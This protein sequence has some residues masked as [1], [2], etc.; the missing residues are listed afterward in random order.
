M[1]QKTEIDHD[2]ELEISTVVPLRSHLLGV[3]GPGLITGA[4]DDDPSGIATYSQ[5]GAQFGYGFGWTMIYSLPLMVAVQMIS[6]RIGR[7][8]GRGLAGV[9]RL[10]YPNWLLQ[11]SVGLLLIAN[12]INLGADLGAMGDALNLLLPGATWLYVIFFGSLCIAMQ[13][14]FTYARY[15]SI[16]KWLTLSLFA[17]LAT[18]AVVHVDWSTM[19]FHAFIPQ[20]SSD[21][22]FL[23]TIVAVFGTTISPYLFFWQSSEE[24]EDVLHY[25]ERTELAKAPEQ[26]PR[27]LERIEVDTIVGMSFSN[28][29][30][31]SIL[32]TAAATFHV[33]GVTDIQTSAQA[34]D[35]LRPLAGHFA[36]LIFTLGI[37]GT[38]FLA[39]PVLA[40]SA[41]YAVGEAMRW[42]VGFGRQMQEAKAFYATVILA[43]IVG[44]ILNFSSINP[45]KALF[46]SAVINGVVAVPIMIIMML[47]A[48]RRD[49]LGRFAIHGWLKVLGWTATALMVVCVVAMFSNLAL[50][51]KS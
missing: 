40:G 18:L 23:P 39:V 15:V 48:S 44:M 20:F 17:Y 43:M 14:V 36:A 28:T 21:A 33:N 26:G 46:W 13:V 1:M 6:A 22:E 30:A 49:I 7:T 38:G 51:A 10:H 24:A 31:L 12:T 47:M 50:G 32:T 41:A 29:I 42:K 16:L 35:A 8:T 3:L 19:L 27:A 4:S 9:L 2:P 11:I 45:I 25:P 5:A 37:I 34:A